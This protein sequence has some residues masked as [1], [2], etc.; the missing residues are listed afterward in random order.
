MQKNSNTT[1]TVAASIRAMVIGS[2]IMSLAV[3]MNVTAQTDETVNDSSTLV[4]QGDTEIEIPKVPL[5]LDQIRAFADVFTR[6]KS[7]YVEHVSDEQL[8]DYAISG[9]LNGLDPHS[10]YLKQER[11]TDLN[12]GTTGKFGGLGIEVVWENGFVKVIAP[13]D[14]TPAFKAGIQS[15]DLIIRIDGEAIQGNDLR[16]ATEKM[17]GEPGTP[18]NLTILREGKSE[19]FDVEF[20][21]AI[22]R[23]SSVKRERLTDQIGYLR[24][25]Q[26]QSGTS[27]SFRK[28]LKMLR[29][30]DGFAGL[31]IDLRNNPG[32][33]LN[34]AISISDSFLTEGVIVSTKGRLVENDTEFKATSVDLIDGKPIIVLINGGS[35][36]A[37]E[38]VAGALQDHERALI[39]GT[40]SFGKG[41]VQTVINL[42]GGDGIKLTTARYFTPNGS[43]IQATGI[44]PDVVV[45]QRDFKETKERFERI[46]EKGL[47][48][49]LENDVKPK[50][51]K[52]SEKTAKKLANDY[53]LNEAFNLLNGLILFGK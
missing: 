22:I 13:I 9:M 32:G 48:G 35:A 36:S 25:T 37:S 45:E 6:I 29:D 18:I 46:K 20:N 40:D 19:P 52:I 12:E 15:G 14:D 28:Q 3:S 27:E 10:V 21:R 30:V 38:I 17:R 51:S 49:H 7:S 26:F 41:S 33:L 42:G 24:I 31:I 1:R 23:I 44:V 2:L 39:L 50:V 43:S 8:L 16:S 53:Q 11:Y 5:P 47:S 34:S 4:T